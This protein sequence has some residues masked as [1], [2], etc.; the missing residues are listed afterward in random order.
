MGTVITTA[1]MATAMMSVW[2]F[3]VVIERSTAD[4]FA[5]KSRHWSD[6]HTKIIIYGIDTTEL[7][8]W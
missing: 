3:I 7:V 1:T 5:D 4:V 2:A 8:M 6:G